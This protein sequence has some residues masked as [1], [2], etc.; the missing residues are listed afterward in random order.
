M[1]KL[2]TT[3]G[4]L[5]FAGKPYRAMVQKIYREMLGVM[6]KSLLIIL[7]IRVLGYRKIGNF[8][9][10]LIMMLKGCSWEEAQSLYFVYI[11]SNIEY[12]MFYAFLIFFIIFMRMLILRFTRYFDEIIA[13]VD[14]LVTG[15]EPIV[16]SP[17]LDFM[18][19]RLTEVRRQLQ[20]AAAVEREAEKKK[21]DFL[22][23]LAHDIRTPLTSVVGYLSLLRQFP[24]QGVEIERKYLNIV[25]D[26]A[27]QL[28]KLVE[29]FFDVT[30]LTFQQVTLDEKP[31]D[32]GC[33]LM[34]L[35][36][37]AYPMAHAVGMTVRLSV[38]SEPMMVSADPDKL[39]RALQNLLRNAV[40]YGQ[41]GEILISAHQGE[42]QCALS[43][44]NRGQ[45]PQEELDRFFE[46]FYRGDP[47]R[48]SAPNGNSTGGAG[49]GLV[50]ARDI[51]RLHGGSISA[52]CQDGWI[53]FR[54]L[55]PVL[56]DSTEKPSA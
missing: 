13:G 22:L 2:R 28:Q 40:S 33:M 53:T 20:A 3:V 1:E 10:E 26:K 45:V 55:L 30:R 7:A 9:A 27:L 54:V 38:Q 52:G 5:F 31:V 41:K 37:E 43:V 15:D 24:E 39:A 34:Q 56:R 51:I 48:G 17:E 11:R 19:I 32:I 25:L 46:R 18:E 8:L 16:L 4:S 21:N 47:S 23:Y 36:D 44:S 50:I 14:Q 49:L 29:E 42:N 35:A 6:A 12:L